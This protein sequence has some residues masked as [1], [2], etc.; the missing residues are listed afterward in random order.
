VRYTVQWTEAARNDLRGIHDYLL[1]VT[2]RNTAKR[3]VHD[4]RQ[5]T[6]F[7]PDHP[8][9]YQVFGGSIEQARH[10]VIHRWRLL[11]VIDDAEKRCTVASVVDTSR[12]I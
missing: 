7:L 11:Y 4:I 12:K 10:I 2:S 9:L 3:L 5:S 8:R 1:T 6:R